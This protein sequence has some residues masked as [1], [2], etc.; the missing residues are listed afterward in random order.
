MFGGLTSDERQSYLDVLAARFTLSS[1]L[2]RICRR[3]VVAE[4][5]IVV[6]FVKLWRS[7]T[8]LTK[9]VGLEP[10]GKHRPCLVVHMRT[11]RD[12]EHI[13]ELCTLG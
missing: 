10:V 5:G 3:W 12:A 4:L 1:L 11:G 2:G 9:H 13:I 8:L 6:E 7:E